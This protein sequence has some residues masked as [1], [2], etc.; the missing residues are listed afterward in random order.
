MKKVLIIEDEKS[1]RN[2]IADIL[3]FE[4]FDVYE[5]ENGLAGVHLAKEV[6]PDI[7]LCDIMM[8]K[9]DGHE[10]LRQLRSENKT[11]LFPFVFMTALADHSDVRT[12]MELGADDYLTKPFLR[13]EL[14]NAINTRLQKSEAIHQQVET[15]VDDLRK[16]VIA[17]LPHELLTPLN[18]ILGFTD[19][20]IMGADTLPTHKL[21]EMAEIMKGSGERLLSLINRFILYIQ[22]ISEKDEQ[23]EE[24]S[25]NITLTATYISQKVA[26]EHKRMKDL[27][28]ELKTQAHCLM[29]EQ[30]FAIVLQEILDNA[31]KFSGPRN[32]VKISSIT[33]DAYHGISIHNRGRFFPENSINQLGAF[34]QFDR[35]K[36]EQQGVGLGLIISKLILDKYKGH[37]TIESDE[38]EG[39]TVRIFIPIAEVKAEE[40]VL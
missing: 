12:G 15:M 23:I 16:R 30:D 22:L 19:L 38:D 17:H 4:G 36:Y 8:P 32:K 26:N 25:T 29:N 13:D 7:I 11:K 33:Q 21:I 6:L 9:M 20:I 24:E 2:G 18:G 5:A 39:T 40:I 31:F 37:L 14:L 27:V 10:V 3:M 34:I 28:V 35:K 1:I